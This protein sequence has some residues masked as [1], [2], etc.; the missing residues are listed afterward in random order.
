MHDGARPILKECAWH[1]GCRCVLL[2][3]LCP[4]DT[5][6]HPALWLQVYFKATRLELEHTVFSKK[7][8]SLEWTTALARLGATPRHKGLR[9]LFMHSQWA[10]CTSWPQIG[11]WPCSGKAPRVKR[12]LITSWMLEENKDRLCPPKAET[13]TPSGTEHHQQWTIAHCFKDLT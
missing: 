1:V 11:R 8:P 13:D 12:I 7:K 5:S 10:L 6:T 2:S 3:T 9:S 4:S